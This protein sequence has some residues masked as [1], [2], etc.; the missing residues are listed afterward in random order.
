MYV[1][2][3]MSMMF[4]KINRTWGSF[5]I[6]DEKHCYFVLIDS[7]AANGSLMED[8]SVEESSDNEDSWEQVGP[9]KKSVLTR[10]V[11]T[12]VIVKA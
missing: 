9:K 11:C 12:R 1:M 8:V 2:H 10:R 4:M 5:K 7:N 6:W 3:K